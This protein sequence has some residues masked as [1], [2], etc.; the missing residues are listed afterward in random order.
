MRDASHALRGDCCSRGGTLRREAIETW[1][2]ERLRERQR[3]QTLATRSDPYPFVGTGGRRRKPR[4]DV[5][6]ASA[7]LAR[8]PRLERAHVVAALPEDAVLQSKPHR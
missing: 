1:S 3:Q 7:R 5:D 6:Q 4:V 2:P 8:R